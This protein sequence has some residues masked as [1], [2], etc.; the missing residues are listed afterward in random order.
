MIKPIKLIL[1]ILFFICLLNM[2]YGYY[3]FVRFVAMIG[4][5]FLAI[6]EYEENKQKNIAVV[7][8][9]KRTKYT[10]L[11]IYIALALL[12]QPIIKIALGKTL[13]NIVDLVAGVGLLLS[14]ATQKNI[15]KRMKNNTENLYINN[16]IN[17]TEAHPKIATKNKWLNP[18]YELGILEKGVEFESKTYTRYEKENDTNDF[19]I[20]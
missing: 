15:K 5:I 20:I 4:F 10:P 7:W 3:Q 17:Q 1:S 9:E 19:T 12:F 13:W 16:T 8:V 18:T 6:K 11:F 2:P 14:L